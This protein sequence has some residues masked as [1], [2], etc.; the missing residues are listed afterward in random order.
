MR[1]YTNS[2]QLRSFS[3]WIPVATLTL[4]LKYHYSTA[5][6]AELQWMLQPLA[7]LLNILTGHVFYPEG[8]GEWVSVTADVRLVKS[9]AGIN[10]M[11][12]SLAAYAWIFR[13]DSREEN[14]YWSWLGGQ[15]LLLPT[16]VVFAWATALLANTARILIAMWIQ[17][18]YGLLQ[19]LGLNATEGHRLI[20]LSIYLPLLSLQILAASS[21]N[22]R[23]ALYIPA[24]LYLLLTIIVPLLTGNALHDPKLFLEHAWFLSL[25]ILFLYGFCA[26]IY[27][28][29]GLNKNRLLRFW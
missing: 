3:W 4:L 2:K 27:Y 17:T 25:S 18:D 9:C 26:L 15:A 6:V 11:L 12:M 16:V 22:R 13:P 1:P 20:G 10:F 24:T 7:D 28:L 14:N 8:S 19:T 23:Q 5:T 29:F 21:A